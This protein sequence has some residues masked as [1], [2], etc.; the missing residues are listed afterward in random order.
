VL[1]RPAESAKDLAVINIAQTLPQS[2]AGF[3]GGALLAIGGGGNNYTALFIGAGV[4]CA[5]AAAAIAP[6]RRVR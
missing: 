6:I 1:P 3:V 4:A 5:L 2:L